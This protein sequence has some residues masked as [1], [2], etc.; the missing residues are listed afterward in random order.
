MKNIL[1]LLLTGLL[2]QCTPENNSELSSIENTILSDNSDFPTGD[3]VVEYAKL[4]YG[5]PYYYGSANPQTGFDCSGYIHYVYTHFGIEV[6]RSS[7]DFTEVGTDVEV[8]EAQPGDLVLFTG[9]NPKNRTVGH[10]GIVVKNDL[11]GLDFIHATSGKQHAVTVT[12]LEGYYENRFV[13]V[14]RLI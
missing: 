8:E 12:P 1:M 13:K 6:P 4:Y 5:V 9:T 2:F 10:I 14:I 11:E 3:A 7:V